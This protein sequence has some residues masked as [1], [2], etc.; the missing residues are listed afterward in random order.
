M[1]VEIMFFIHSKK[2][3]EEFVDKTKEFLNI[4]PD[5]ISIIHVFCVSHFLYYL[6]ILYLYLFIHPA[7]YFKDKEDYHKLFKITNKFSIKLYKVKRFSLYDFIVRDVYDSINRKIPK[8]GVYYDT[9]LNETFY[10][11]YSK[12]QDQDIF[13]NESYPMIVAPGELIEN[14]YES[15]KHQHGYENKIAIYDMIEFKNKNQFL[16]FCISGFESLYIPKEI[17]KFRFNYVNFIDENEGDYVISKKYFIDIK[18]RIDP[19]TM[20][21][22][23]PAKFEESEYKGFII[24]LKRP[25][26]YI[27]KYNSRVF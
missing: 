21:I 18:M 2:D 1:N 8:V 6:F 12:G 19:D 22:I 24:S 10:I 14:K 4:N 17:E 26:L 23:E 25:I 13:N 16:Y 27:S 15:M 5:Q 20:G 9:S 3:I 7:I 11:S